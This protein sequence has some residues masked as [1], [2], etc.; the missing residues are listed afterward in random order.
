MTLPQTCNPTQYPLTERQRESFTDTCNL[1]KPTKLTQQ[2]GL[3]DEFVEDLEFDPV[4]AFTNVPCLHRQTDELAPTGFLGQTNRDTA[5][6][7]DKWHFASTQYFEINWGILK[8]TPGAADNGRFW[9]TQGNPKSRPSIGE[10][11]ANNNKV[12]ALRSPKPLGIP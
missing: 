2:I 6:F 10:R 5:M 8:T 3:L 9:V 4:P 11:S 1:Y 12:F 7:I